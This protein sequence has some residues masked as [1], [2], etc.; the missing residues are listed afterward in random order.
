MPPF[1]CLRS[2]VKGLA[3]DCIKPSFRRIINNNNDDDN[4]NKKNNKPRELE[5]SEVKIHTTSSVA[6]INKGRILKGVK[7]T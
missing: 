4:N 1:F 7:L 3:D 5:I 6:L 2:Q